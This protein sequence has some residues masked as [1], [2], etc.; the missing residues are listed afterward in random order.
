MKM[1]CAKYGLIFL[2]PLQKIGNQHFPT[3]AAYTQ[4]YTCPNVWHNTTRYEHG[5]GTTRLSSHA[6]LGQHYQPG[7]D[8]GTTRQCTNRVMLCRGTMNIVVRCRDKP[9]Y[10]N[11]LQN[12]QIQTDLD[13]TTQIRT[14]LHRPNR[15]FTK[16][17]NINVILEL[18]CAMLSH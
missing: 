14:Q 5:L 10:R 7:H 13:T 17:N 4:D 2:C 3:V 18:L 6:E 11:M 9:E 16:L 12:T 1:S 8:L 15:H